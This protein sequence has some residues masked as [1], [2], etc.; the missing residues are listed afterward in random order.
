MIDDLVKGN[1][2][3]PHYSYSRRESVNNRKDTFS[4][5]TIL[6]TL[7]LPHALFFPVSV[8]MYLPIYMSPFDQ[9]CVI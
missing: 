7:L 9:F 8:L 1:E 3:L 2:M 6:K 4:I 5:F